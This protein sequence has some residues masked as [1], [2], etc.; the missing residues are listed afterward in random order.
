M[1]GLLFLYCIS[2]PSEYAKKNDFELWQFEGV[3]R[4]VQ[5]QKGVVFMSVRTGG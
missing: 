2:G 5:K 4:T 3:A 1:P